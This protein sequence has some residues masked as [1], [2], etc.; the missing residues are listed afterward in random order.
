M[1][2]GRKPPNDQH[3]ALRN[4]RWLLDYETGRPLDVP[5]IMHLPVSLFLLRK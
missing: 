3:M 1:A 4:L 2:S 5:S